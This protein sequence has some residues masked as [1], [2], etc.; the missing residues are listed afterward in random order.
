MDVITTW[1][2]A[3]KK[4]PKG[5]GGADKGADLVSLVVKVGTGKGS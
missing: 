4:T 1:R 3:N 5:G 2:E